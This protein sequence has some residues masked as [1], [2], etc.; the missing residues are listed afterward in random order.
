MPS[1]GMRLPFWSSGR[2]R[3]CLTVSIAY[4]RTT[5]CVLQSALHL[6]SFLREIGSSHAVLY[7]VFGR[8][9]SL[10]AQKRCLVIWRLS[11]V[12]PCTIRMKS[13]R[14]TLTC[15]TYV[16]HACGDRASQL[17]SAAS[18]AAASVL[19][20]CGGLLSARLSRWCGGTVLHMYMVSS[21]QSLTVLVVAQK[22]KDDSTYPMG[23]EKWNQTSFPSSG[24]AYGTKKATE[25]VSS[26]RTHMCM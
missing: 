12:P 3:I 18:M 1:R 24:V 21:A 16:A 13:S 14:Y 8:K 22:N 5:F 23:I 2:V 19:E 15:A 11:S 10:M 17:L 9:S 26:R 20:V 7:L 6:R 25:G 4:P